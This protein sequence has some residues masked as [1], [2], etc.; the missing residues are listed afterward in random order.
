MRPDT[1]KPVNPKRINPKRIK[2]MIRTGLIVVLLVAA[3][4]VVTAVVLPGYVQNHLLPG[5]G[6]SIGLNPVDMRVR[7]IGMW[8][9][10]L[11]PI[12]LTADGSPALTVAAVQVDYS[13]WGLMR[14][15][16][17]GL[18]IVGLGV[19][20]AQTPQGL[21]IAGI[22]VP[23]TASLSED[24]PAGLDL[25]T[26][27]PIPVKRLAIVQSQLTLEVAGRR[28]LIPFDIELRSHPSEGDR[29]KGEADLSVSGNPVTLRAS[30][31]PKAGMA[32]FDMEAAGFELAGLAPWVSSSR[33]VQLAGHVDIQGRARLGIQPLD[34]KGLALTCRSTDIL[35]A[36]PHGRLQP[37][38]DE[39][40]RRQPVAVSV[41]G[42]SLSRLKWRLAPFRIAGPVD[43]AV[44]ELSGILDH[45]QGRW[46]LSGAAKTVLAEQ[47]LWYRVRLPSRWETKWGLTGYRADAQDLWEFQLA[48]QD[49]GPLTLAAND[50]ELTAQHATARISG[51]MKSGFLTTE[52]TLSVKGIRIVSPMGN[53]SVPAATFDAAVGLSP[54][55]AGAP[56]TIEIQARLPGGHADTGATTV[57]LPET[58]FTASGKAAPRDPWRFDARL[59]LSKGRITDKK[60]RMRISK[61]SADL[62]LKWPLT[63]DA[64]PGRLSAGVVEWHKQSI[65]GVTGT[66]QQ[67]R[68]GLTMALKHRSKLFPG[69]NVLINGRMNRSGAAT[70]DAQAPPY[71]I[72]KAI[73]LGR[74]HPAAAGMMVTGKIEAAVQ[75]QVAD[76]RLDGDLRF[77]FEKGRLRQPS[78]NLLL[79]GIDTQIHIDDMQRMQSAPQQR[80]RVSRVTMGKLKAENL[81]VDFRVESRG[82]LFVEKAQIDWCQGKINAAA[83]RITPGRDEYETILFCDRL[84]LSMVLKELGAAEA[85]GD[86][87]VNGRIPVL[88][89]NGRLHFDNGFLYSSPGQTG[90]IRLS[91][92]EALLSGMPPDSPQRVQLDIATEALKDYTYKWAKL[93]VQ[94]EDDTLLLKLQFDGKPNRLLPFAYDGQSGQFKRVAGQ[95]LADFEG[96][97]IDLNLR[98]PLNEILNYKALLK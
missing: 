6:R 91:G 92:T 58:T 60:R 46:T 19:H 2:W 25:H 22:R 59:K 61:L 85:Q 80:L 29:L 71:R 27:F 48:S 69:M 64:P 52:S 44:S 82:T 73:D 50:A 36:T 17:D 76:G 40:G 84:N 14:G 75:A 68:Q 93:S 89:A 12:R 41:T 3:L 81:K 33:P 66:L 35:L 7:R 77:K 70:I 98:T 96:L 26:L 97:S 55:D 42:D 43:V 65:G 23:T 79:E 63:A 74:F 18:T 47:S 87:A 16:I 28:Y 49:G 45:A 57:V 95:G 13:P 53:L 30:L 37:M 31:D 90:A 39:K 32:D 83:L 56:A 38:T 88:W 24:G 15:K 86:G 67:K 20:V 8:G 4:F 34:L 21:S 94:T 54:S 11:G 1:S 10:D 72:A 5:L 51:S 62:P 78:R 9:S